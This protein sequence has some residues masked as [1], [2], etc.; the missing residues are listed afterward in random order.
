MSS[1]QRALLVFVLAL[2][3]LAVSIVLLIE[4]HEP[5]TVTR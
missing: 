5:I 2:V 1:G 4:T 3:L